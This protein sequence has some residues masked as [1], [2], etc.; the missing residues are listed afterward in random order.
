MDILFTENEFAPNLSS[1][2]LSDND[3][4]LVQS[5]ES[6]KN[7]YHATQII[8]DQVDEYYRDLLNKPLP[9]EFI[10]RFS[11]DT[12]AIDQAIDH[13]NYYPL[14]ESFTRC[15]EESG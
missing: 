10:H 15:P 13:N 6:A 14:S 12:E 3:F 11:I 1:G 2:A 9:G 7:V 4:G 5:T 8:S